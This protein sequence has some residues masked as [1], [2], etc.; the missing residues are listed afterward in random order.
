MDIGKTVGEIDGHLDGRIDEQKNC[1]MA[2]WN[3]G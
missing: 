2:D 1:Y 3:N